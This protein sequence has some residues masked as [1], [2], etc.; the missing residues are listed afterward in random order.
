MARSSFHYELKQHPYEAHLPPQTI[1]ATLAALEPKNQKIFEERQAFIK[2]LHTAL[3]YFREFETKN[4]REAFISSFHVFEKLT[5]NPDLPDDIRTTVCLS[6]YN[7]QMKLRNLFLA[8][9]ALNYCTQPH[10]KSILIARAKLLNAQGKR[11]EAHAVSAFLKTLT[12]LKKKP[13]PT[14]KIPTA[15]RARSADPVHRF[16]LFGTDDAPRKVVEQI[17]QVQRA[18]KKRV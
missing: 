11:R 8:E 2:E 4:S 16:G 10:D 15:S 6:L 14:P 7:C 5:K 1:A 18:E 17:Q 12:E 9:E 3:Y 13:E